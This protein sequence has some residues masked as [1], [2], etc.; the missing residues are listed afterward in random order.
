VT[1]QLNPEQE[2]IVEQ[3][4]QAGLI[5]SRDEIAEVGVASIRHTLIARHADSH[6]DS[7]QEWSRA[8]SS[9]NEGHATTT[10]LLPDKA[11]DRE[12]TDGTRYH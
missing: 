4:L 5:S 8:L 12:S 7:A 6:P 2:R 3:A 10:P 9:W 1:I 11:V